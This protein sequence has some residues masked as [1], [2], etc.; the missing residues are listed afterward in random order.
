MARSGNN[1]YLGRLRRF[2][3]ISHIEPELSILGHRLFSDELSVTDLVIFI[4][5]QTEIDMAFSDYPDYRH[6]PPV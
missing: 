2:I 6:N 4:V 5:P 3:G 1:R